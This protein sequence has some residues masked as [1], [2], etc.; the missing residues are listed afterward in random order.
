MAP[1]CSGD[2]PGRVEGI[3][4]GALEFD[5]TNDYVEVPHDP[6]LAFTGSFTAAAWIRPTDFGDG[7][8]GRILAKQKYAGGFG[9]G[10]SFYLGDRPTGNPAATR[11]LCANIDAA[12]GCGDDDIVTPGIWQ[13]VTLVFDDDADRVRFYVDGLSRGG[14]DTTEQLDA[15]TVPLRIGDRDDL[16]RSFRGTIDD[17]KLWGRVLSDAEIINLP[18]LQD[19]PAVRS[20]G[21]PTGNLPLALSM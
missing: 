19:Q 2:A 1:N 6:A 4:A 11:S 18:I 10:Y 12:F 14:F 21:I 15:S 20:N 3:V 13:H 5:G 17:V 16:L 9:S 8:Y 7:D